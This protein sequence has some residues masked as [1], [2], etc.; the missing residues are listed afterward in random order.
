VAHPPARGDLKSAAVSEARK[1]FGTPV[2]RKIAVRVVRRGRAMWPG[3]QGGWTRKEWN[4]QVRLAGR[5]FIQNTK[6]SLNQ[7]H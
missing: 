5:T 6:Q 1:K 7:E 2:V 4:Y 3:L